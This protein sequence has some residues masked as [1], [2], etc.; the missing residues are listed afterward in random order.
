MKKIFALLIALI[1]IT[2]TATDLHVIEW[3]SSKTGINYR[4]YTSEYINQHEKAGYRILNFKEA[5]QESFEINHP[6]SVVTLEGK[7]ISVHTHT[8]ENTYKEVIAK[9]NPKSNNVIFWCVDPTGVPHFNRK[10]GLFVH[11]RYV[12]LTE[13]DF[14]EKQFKVFWNL[15]NDN[16]WEKT[17]KTEKYAD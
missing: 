6:F 3:T 1:T 9:E 17:D 2:A 4:S 8:F 14:F 12:L 7:E 5:F 13:W 11:H 15:T 16:K 10:P